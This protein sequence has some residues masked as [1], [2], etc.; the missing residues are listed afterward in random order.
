MLKLILI[1]LLST[2]TLF[3]HGKLKVAHMLYSSLDAS[4]KDIKTTLSLWMKDLGQHVDIPIESNFYTSIEDIKKDIAKGKVNYMMIRSIDAVKYFNTNELISGYAPVRLKNSTH[5]TLILITRKDSN[6]KNLRDLKNKEFGLYVNE[7]VGKLYIDTLLMQKNL[8]R[9]KKHFSKIHK[10]TKRSKVLL[11]LF[12]KKIDAAIITQGTL[13]LV[14]EM[15]P[16][17]GK[18]IKIIEKKSL[19][20]SVV[21]FFAKDTEQHIID[22]FVD[23]I[24]KIHDSERSKQIL[25]LFKANHLEKTDKKDLEELQKFYI[26]Y[27]KLNKGVMK[28]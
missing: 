18:S 26:Y 20:L 23:G 5:N 14:N 22:K 13:D 6:F 12:F 11:D 17:I 16:Q 25:T 21:G 27:Q 1:L 24:E 4:P 19:S 9:Y 15:N 2:S 28:K 3:A 7:E 10:Y 8:P